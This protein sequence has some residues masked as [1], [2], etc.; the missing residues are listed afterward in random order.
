M[1]IQLGVCGK[2]VNVGLK[3]GDFRIVPEH[4][5]LEELEINIFDRADAEIAWLAH[6]K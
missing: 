2:V 4:L 1:P 6:E 5:S 3:I